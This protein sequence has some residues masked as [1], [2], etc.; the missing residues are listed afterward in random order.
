MYHSIYSIYSIYS[1]VSLS[2]PADDYSSD[3]TLLILFGS[4][5]QG[6]PEMSLKQKKK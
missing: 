5:Q 6:K 4:E 2:I 3:G 1:T